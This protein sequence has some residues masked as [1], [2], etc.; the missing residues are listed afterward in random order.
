MKTEEKLTKQYD[1]RTY[2]RALRK[3]NKELNKL[4]RIVSTCYT[5][6]LD[7][8]LRLYRAAELKV[9]QLEDRINPPLNGKY[10]IEPLQIMQ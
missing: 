10:D 4:Q 5:D 6:D 9:K 2:M 8:N 7:K 3:A 1:T